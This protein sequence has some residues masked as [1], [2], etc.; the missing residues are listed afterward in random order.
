MSWLEN[1]TEFIK[2]NLNL[3][4]NIDNS[5]NIHT[6]DNNNSRPLEHNE[7]NNLLSINLGKLEPSDLVKFGEIA[8][9][10]HNEGKTLL[11]KQSQERII[12][13]RTKEESTDV[14][15]LL[16]Y[17]Q[18]KIPS[19]DFAI[20]RQAVYI[21]KL[22]DEGG[23][24]AVIY[25]LKGEVG[26]KYGQRGLNI[27]NLF[28]SGYFG[29]TI[30]KLYRGTINQ[31]KDVF[32]EKYNVIINEA[33]FAVFVSGNMSSYDVRNDIEERIK[34]NIKYG[35]RVVTIHGIGKNNVEKI[36]EVIT[37]IGKKNPTFKKQ[38]DI[39]GNIILARLLLE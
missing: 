1:L 17:F 6:T 33:A 14:Q 13:I 7:E 4:I 9:E 26:K 31:G 12:D 24:S 35:I 23:N 32:L 11:E 5:V 25:R 38:I 30:R 37:E 39:N 20:L 29:T 8:K 2:V 15:Q 3:N 21:K 36:V 18:G 22:F 16:A 28:S 34:R 19:Y 27:C 10:A